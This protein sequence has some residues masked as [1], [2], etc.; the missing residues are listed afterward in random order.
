V[1]IP[2]EAT[3]MYGRGEVAIAFDASTERVI[4]WFG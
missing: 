1:S 4:V 3:I 2:L